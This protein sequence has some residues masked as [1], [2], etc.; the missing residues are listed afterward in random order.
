[1]YKLELFDIMMNICNYVF[2]F[3]TVYEAM[4]VF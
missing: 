2:F 4:K 1:M 3:S